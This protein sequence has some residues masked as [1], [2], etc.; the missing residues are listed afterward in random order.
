[1]DLGGRDVTKH[2]MHLLRRAG[3]SFHTS[4]EFEIVRK[5]K[6]R[7]CYAEP[8]NSKNTAS[9]MDKDKKAGLSKGDA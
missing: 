2:L 8:I 9:S 7:Y 6:E 5:I 4:A 1:M 3:H